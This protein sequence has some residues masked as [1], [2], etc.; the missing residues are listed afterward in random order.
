MSNPQVAVPV[1]R[2]RSSAYPTPSI[3][4]ELLS[5]G[6]TIRAAGTCLGLPFHSRPRTADSPSKRTLLTAPPADTAF[7]KR[8]SALLRGLRTGHSFQLSLRSNP[9]ARPDFQTTTRLIRKICSLARP[10]PSL[11]LRA[12]PSG[13]S[14]AEQRFPTLKNDFECQKY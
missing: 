5:S 12:R 10:F 13:G 2:L 4:R 11:R 9:R 7:R 1:L 3:C 8:S 6:S 14:C